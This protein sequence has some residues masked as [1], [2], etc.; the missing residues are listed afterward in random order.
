[1]ARHLRGTSIEENSLLSRSLGFMEKRL[2][3]WGC[4]SLGYLMPIQQVKGRPEFSQKR[5]L[6]S[7]CYQISYQITDLLVIESFNE[8]I[9]ITQPHKSP[10]FAGI[11]IHYPSSRIVRKHLRHLTGSHPI[12]FSRDQALELNRR[13]SVCAPCENSIKPLKL[14]R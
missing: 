10:K 4:R 2:L 1:M 3:I 13:A 11:R 12:I 8:V 5:T 6:S 7:F 14:Y 9:A